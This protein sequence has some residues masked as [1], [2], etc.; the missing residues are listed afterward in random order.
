MLYSVR[1]EYEVAT[2]DVSRVL[3]ALDQTVSGTVWADPAALIAEAAPVNGYALVEVEAASR[4]EAHRFVIAALRDADP[5]QVVITGG[6]IAL[7]PV[8]GPA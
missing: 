1:L 3:R 6:D 2:G 7:M 8:A 5:D 4:D